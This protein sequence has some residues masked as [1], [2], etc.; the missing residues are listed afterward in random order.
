LFASAGNVLWNNRTPQSIR[1][2]RP[3]NLEFLKESK[4][5]IMKENLHI[6]V[7]MENYMQCGPVRCGASKRAAGTNRVPYSHLFVST[8]TTVSFK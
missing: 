3:L 6:Q 7:K 2:C 8:S 1:F 4:D 5:V